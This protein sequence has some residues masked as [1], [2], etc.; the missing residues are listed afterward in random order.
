MPL[1]LI[2]TPTTFKDLMNHIFKLFLDWFAVVFIDDILVNS[3]SDKE[4]MKNILGKSCKFFRSESYS[5]NI[6][7]VNFG[8]EK[9][10][11]SGRSFS[12][13]GALADSKKMEAIRVWSLPT[14]ITKVWNFV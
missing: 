4:S 13:V 12:K 1:G 3:Q 10:S 7:C 14:N 2:N 5:P 6:K 9:L 8:S 11:F